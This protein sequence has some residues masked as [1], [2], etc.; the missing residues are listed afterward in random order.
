MSTIEQKSKQLSKQLLVDENLIIALKVRET[1]KDKK[2]WC[3]YIRN[4][5]NGRH[6]VIGHVELALGV[7]WDTTRETRIN[8]FFE[9]LGYTDP[10]TPSY[11]VHA[12]RLMEAVS[13]AAVHNNHHTHAEV[14]AK[15][16]A[17]IEHLKETINVQS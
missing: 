3:Q 11:P 8:E 6:C 17:G 9:K 14:L 16:D 5:S 4:D 2:R 10:E 13:V 7:S 12:S 1:L 15:F